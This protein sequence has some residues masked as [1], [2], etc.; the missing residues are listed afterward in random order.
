MRVSHSSH[1]T[2]TSDK[3]GASWLPTSGGRYRALSCGYSRRCMPR[4]S[5]VPRRRHK[6]CINRSAAP[7]IAIRK[8]ARSTHASFLERTDRG[9]AEA[10]S[11]SPEA[12]RDRA[13]TN[14][15]HHGWLRA[16]ITPATSTMQ[17]HKVQAADGGPNVARP[18]TVLS[19]Q[20]PSFRFAQSAQPDHPPLYPPLRI[21]TPPC[22][23]QGVRRDGSRGNMD[24]L[25]MLSKARNSMTTRS[26]PMPPPACGNA[27][28]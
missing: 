19:H 8:R 25:R 23:H 12:R 15:H 18:S 1:V 21:P 28:Y 6:T 26:M 17:A 13:A 10:R 22:A 20:R 5:S 14:Q 4:R 27:P 11:T 7:A 3:P 9:A 2:G 16:P 24:D